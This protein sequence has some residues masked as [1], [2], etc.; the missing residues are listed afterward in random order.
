MVLVVIAGA[1]VLAMRSNE[2]DRTVRTAG[3]AVTSTL[4]T[5]ADVQ[6]VVPEMVVRVFGSGRDVERV[7]PVELRPSTTPLARVSFTRRWT[8]RGE[9]R[10]QAPLPDRVWLVTATVSEFD[11]EP[12]ATRNLRQLLLHGNRLILDFTS[13]PFDELEFGRVIAQANSV[14]AHLP[15][16]K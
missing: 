12:S 9:P 16:A 3:P 14:L 5:T 7:T 6:R 13:R 8:W 4:L 1:A 2:G 11:D 10:V 15:T